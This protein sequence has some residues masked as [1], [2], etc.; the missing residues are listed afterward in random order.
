MY[1]ILI[2]KK[3][4]SLLRGGIVK[5][6]AS[7]D[8]AWESRSYTEQREY[9]KQHPKSKKK[10]TKAP[11]QK[12]VSDSDREYSS[13]SIPE[14]QTTIKN[15]Q[16]TESTKAFNKL[17]LNFMPLILN[18][19]RKVIGQ[20]SVSKDDVDDLKQHANI[21]FAKLMST[22][23][24]TNQG[25]ISYI[26]TSLYKQLIGKS[27]EIF[28]STVTIGP[29]DRRALRAVQKYIHKYYTEHGE[30]PTDYE[31]MAYDI[32]NDP[33]SRSSHLTADLIRDLLQ[34]NAVSIEEEVGGD[35]SGE[36]GRKR[37]DLIG[38]DQL[39]QDYSTLTTT[40]EEDIVQSEFK[41]TVRKS[42]DLIPDDLGRRVLE[43][44]YG[45]DK[46]HL[47]AERNFNVISD[48]LGKP[49]KT[50]RRLLQKAMATLRSMIEIQKLRNASQILRIIK[51]FDKHVRF[52]YVPQV[53]KKISSRKT[54][55]DQFEVSKFANQLVCSCG[56]INCFHKDIVRKQR[57]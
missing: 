1:K 45:F 44:Y 37:E 49:R 29:K 18:T 4:G 34:S 54:L 27:R 16:E 51:S 10:I 13:M 53:V 46:E 26:A 50:T 22:A 36:K 52:A 32:S 57:S 7:D 9:L 14:I 56:Q 2:S 43:L 12:S 11:S 55:V 17:Y 31:Q 23:D 20:R 38:P 48:I 19:V 5:S 47:E 40:P 35:D 39:E 15:F 33:S 42:I 8:A 21:I 3:L 6:A 41:E 24:F 30:M 28:R 25:V